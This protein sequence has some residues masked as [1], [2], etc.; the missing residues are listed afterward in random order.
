MKS[1]DISVIKSTSDYSVEKGNYITCFMSDGSIWTTDNAGKEWS[2]YK[3]SDDTFT[4]LF[5]EF[6]SSNKDVQDAVEANTAGI[7]SAI[8]E[9]NEPVQTTPDEGAVL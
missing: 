4:K 3:A 8:L 5:Q 6:L 9:T 2:I 1:T 7:P